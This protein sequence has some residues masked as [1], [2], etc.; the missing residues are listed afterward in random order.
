MR[1]KCN[2]IGVHISFR[3]CVN[4]YTGVAFLHSSVDC[5]YSVR[6]PPRPLKSLGTLPTVIGRLLTQLC[7]SFQWQL[8][9]VMANKMA[10]P[11]AW[12]PTSTS[13]RPAQVLASKKVMSHEGSVI[14][15]SGPDGSESER[16]DIDNPMNVSVWNTPSV[17]VLFIY[18]YDGLLITAPMRRPWASCVI[19][20]SL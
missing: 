4:E 12:P 19:L 13:V 11:L 14:P 15:D 6:I 18:R 3:G 5:M 20:S 17:L 1:R 10:S 16:V 2:I 9:A 7:S 8:P